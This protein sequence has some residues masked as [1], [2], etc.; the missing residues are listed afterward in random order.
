MFQAK[1]KLIEAGLI[2]VKTTNL[3]SLPLYLAVIGIRTWEIGVQV[4]DRNFYTTSLFIFHY[5]KSVKGFSRK[6][7]P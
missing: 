5:F 2:K 4:C 1:I 7:N 3:T 6:K